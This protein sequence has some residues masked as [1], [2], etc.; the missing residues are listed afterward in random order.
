MS[1]AL[2]CV[3]AGSGRRFG[4]EKLFQRIDSRTVIQ[5]SVDALRAAFPDAPLTIV[6]APEKLDVWKA[7]FLSAYPDLTI[8]PGGSRRQDSVRQGVEQVR[9]LG[10]EVVAVHDAARPLVHVVDI[11]RVVAAIENSDGAILCRNVIDTVKRVDASGRVMETVPRE[12]LRLA[13]TPQ[14]FKIEALER[15]WSRDRSGE[16]WTDEAALLEAS[17]SKVRCIVAEYPNPKLTTQAD[18]ALMRAMVRG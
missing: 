10:A 15:A 14:V 18:L 12:T 7:S 6:V 11:R 17:G 5:H 4:G 1:L 2:I 13:L 9:Q 8:V 3:A 16:E